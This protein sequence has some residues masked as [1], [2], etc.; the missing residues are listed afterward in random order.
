ML[1]CLASDAALGLPIWLGRRIRI[2]LALYESYESNDVSFTF[3][4]LAI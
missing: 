4:H 2:P 3:R 1:S